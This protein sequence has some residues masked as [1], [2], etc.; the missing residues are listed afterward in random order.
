M[1]KQPTFSANQ[2]SSRARRFATVI[3][4]LYTQRGLRGKLQTLDRAARHLSFGVRLFDPMQLDSALKLAEP[5]ALSCGVN[6]VL[7]QR[8]EGVVSYQIELSQ[9][10]WE[11]YNRADLP[12]PAAVGL[13]ERRRPI[14]FELD[15]A[16]TL[17][18]G[19]TGSGKSEALKSILLSLINSFTPA[20]LGLVLIDPHND[21]S[22]FANEA[23]LVI[24]I[25]RDPQEITS[26]LAWA[27]QELARRKAEDIRDGKTIVVAIGE[28]AES[29]AKSVNLQAA[30]NIARQARKYHVHLV[31]ETQK[32]TASDLPGIFDNLL[33]RFIGQ[34]SDAKVSAN[35][36][37][38]SGLQAHKLTGKGDF[39]HLA[40]PEVRRFQ[41]A[42]ATG[43]DFRQLERGEIAPV[44]VDPVDLVDLPGE[45]TEGLPQRGRPEF[46]PCD[47]ELMAFYFFHDPRQVSRDMARQVLNLTR[48][49]HEAYK[50]FV[51]RFVA[52][53]L[54]FKNQKQIGA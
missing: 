33:N 15:P 39:I 24:S 52:A 9:A 7:A 2:V 49:Q 26:A 13:G 4:L 34:L 31:C 22:D 30:Q 29:L 23:H 50:D 19:A 27:N 12:T 8:V 43:W 47:P 20:E 38:H 17:V 51:M 40:G 44:T 42:I 48:T 32:P 18:A 53:Y 36:T 10:F 45:F 37:G 1:N 54:K 11:F 41:V 6:A 16:H 3:Q 35:V 14:L 25:A 21:Y 28:A 46:R 5:M